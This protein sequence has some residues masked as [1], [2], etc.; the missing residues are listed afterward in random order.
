MTIRR[1]AFP[2]LFAACGLLFAACGGGDTDEGGDKIPACPTAGTTLTYD[3]FGKQ[4]FASYCDSCHTTAAG[5]KA[6]LSVAT[7]D[8]LAQ[9]AAETSRIYDEAGGTNTDMPQGT[10]TPTDAERQQLGEWLSCGAK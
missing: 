2:L 5:N 1:F 9:I 3:N 8:T 6:A 4:F 7:Y 10:K